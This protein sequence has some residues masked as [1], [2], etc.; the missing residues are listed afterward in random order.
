MRV[1]WH[2]FY[3]SSSSRSRCCNSNSRTAGST[4][5][6][7][8]GQRA[9]KHKDVARGVDACR[10]HRIGP[11]DAD[12]AAV[13]DWH[14]AQTGWRGVRISASIPLLPPGPGELRAWPY[15]PA[16]RALFPELADRLAAGDPRKYAIGIVRRVRV[17]APPLPGA[18]QVVRAGADDAHDSVS[19]HAH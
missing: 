14:V 1:R 9:R 5:R 4:T 13:D 15:D 2:G 16:I 18:R 3:S 10:A 8:F 6:A 17:R 19:G 7:G 12:T 11:A